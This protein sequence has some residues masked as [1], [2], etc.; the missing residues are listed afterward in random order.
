M[1]QYEQEL[2]VVIAGAGFGGLRMLHE[3]RQLGYNVTLFEKGAALGG[4][5]YWNCYPGARVDSNS[6]IYQFS[7]KEIWEEWTWSERY[8]SYEEIR[9]Y[10]AFVDKKWNLSENIEFNS[11]VTQARFEETTH[12]WTI[13][14]G[15]G[16][17]VRA[18]W[19]ISALGFASKLYV[20]HMNGLENFKG[21][22]FHTAAWP[23]GGIDTKGKRVAVIG[24]GA[25]GVQ[26]I[27]SLA[28]E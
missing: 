10:L 16:K 13:T 26:V 25:S 15:S 21:T 27:Q 12:Q 3:L 11:V 2:D 14:L 19:F 18:R 9:R 17:I 23:Q 22:C 5:W 1:K 4:I 7:S 24:T 6:L 20:P 8:P 28:S